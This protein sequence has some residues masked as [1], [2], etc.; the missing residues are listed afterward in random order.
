MAPAALTSSVVALVPTYSAARKATMC[1]SAATARTAPS[2]VP[3]KDEPRGQRGNNDFLNAGDGRGGD[4][5]NGGN[6]NPDECRSDNQDDR[7]ASCEN[8]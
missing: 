5:L 6:G 8:R 2:T 1:F 3:G 4:L 7:A